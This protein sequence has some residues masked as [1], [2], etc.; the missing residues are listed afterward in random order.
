MPQKRTQ[1]EPLVP[2]LR[3]YISDTTDGEWELLQPF[4]APDDG[5]GA[6]RTIETR[7][8]VD[9][10]RYRLRTGCQ[11]RQLPADFPPWTTVYY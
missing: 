3:R 4:V 1:T 7:A 8:V 10:L 11:W 2:R 5:P 9:A 6:P